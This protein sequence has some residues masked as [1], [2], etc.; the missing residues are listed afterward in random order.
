MFNFLLYKL[1]AILA[2]SLS[3][4]MAYRLAEFFTDLHLFFSPRDRRALINNL[5]IILPEAKNF[6]ILAREVSRNFGRYLVD[7]FRFPLV[8][9][10][11]IRENIRCE[12]LKF[13]DESLKK[14]KGVIIVSGHLGSWELGAVTLAQLGYDVAAVVLTHKQRLVNNFF[15]QQRK[16]KGLHIIELSNAARQCLEYLRQNKIIILLVDRDFTQNGLIC[17][18]LTKKALLPKGAAIFSLKTGASI[19]PG[20]LIRN[21]DNTFC[22]HFDNSIEPVYTDN[23]DYDIEFLMKKYLS[24]IEGYIKKSPTQWL[25]FREFWIK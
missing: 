19:I 5:N 2:Q 9:E 22:L 21:E 16:S 7:F 1:G 17:D 24:I 10:Q 25:M 14:G 15:N 18:F 13:I 11:F 12:N 20:L 3:R 23:R 6:S 8:N 4:D